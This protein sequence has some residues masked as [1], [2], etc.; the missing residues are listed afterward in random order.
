MS[1]VEMHE[2]PTG[3]ADA[4]LVVSE[5]LSPE[6]SLEEEKRDETDMHRMGKTQELMVRNTLE[7]KA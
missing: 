5:R 7:V 4:T 3:K 1:A 2:V 6:E